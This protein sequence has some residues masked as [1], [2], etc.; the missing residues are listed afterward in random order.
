M[1]TYEIVTSATN[2]LGLILLAYALM[3][4]TKVYVVLTQEL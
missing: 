3:I 4:F 1:S 2:F